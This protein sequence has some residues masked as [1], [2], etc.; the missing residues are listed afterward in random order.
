MHKQIYKMKN[1]EFQGI[2]RNQNIL[3]WEESTN[4]FPGENRSGAL[5]VALFYLSASILAVSS[6]SY[7]E[8]TLQVNILSDYVE[9][10]EKDF[11]REGWAINWSEKKSD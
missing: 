7:S 3:Y 6:K 1:T 10:N 4:T 5:S 8:N 9:I 11:I 2:W